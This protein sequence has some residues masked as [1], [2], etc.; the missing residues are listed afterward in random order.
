MQLN[1]YKVDEA[2]PCC[3]SNDDQ[4]I[5]NTILSDLQYSTVLAFIMRA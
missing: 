5:M 1:V 4:L 3:F 2:K